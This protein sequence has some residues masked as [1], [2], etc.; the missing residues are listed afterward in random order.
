MSFGYG[1]GANMQRDHQ[2]NRTQL[3]KRKSLKEIYDTYE[4]AKSDS[5]EAKYKKMS[6]EE[7]RLF[8]EKLAVE[9]KKDRNKSQILLVFLIFL[10]VLAIS[11]MFLE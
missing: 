6:P 5:I 3:E 4:G 9:R 7:F 2:R 1:P 11:L 8:Q 10:G